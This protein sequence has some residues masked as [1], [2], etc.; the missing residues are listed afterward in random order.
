M[1]G[2]PLALF[3]GLEGSLQAGRQAR[4][5]GTRRQQGGKGCTI[6]GHNIWPEYAGLECFGDLL[7]TWP[8]DTCFKCFWNLV[9]Q[10]WGRGHQGAGTQ[11]PV[12]VLVH[13]VVEVLMLVLVSFAADEW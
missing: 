2:A 6:A 1:D 13:V 10:W 4:P 7:K 12:R 8:E 11:A 9:K 3:L 5:G